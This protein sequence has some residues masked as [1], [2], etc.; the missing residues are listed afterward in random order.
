MW[1]ESARTPL[2]ELL[3]AN[4]EIAKHA[5]RAALEKMLD[6]ANYLGRSGVMVDRVLG[7]YERGR[8]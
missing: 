3:V 5:D 8:V 2:I 7:E 6:P 1:R 4:S